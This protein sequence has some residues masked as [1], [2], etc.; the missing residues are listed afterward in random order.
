MP[1]LR[2]ALG[3][4]GFGNV[5]TYVQS[6][7]IVLDSD[8]PADAVGARV[9]ALIAAEFDLEIPVVTRTGDDLARIVAANP[10]AD[11]AEDPKRYQVT[12]LSGALTA[13]TVQRL[14]SLATD[15][16]QLVV[17][18]REVFAWH[19]EGVAR[20]KL[21][22]ALAGKLGV[23]ATARNWTTVTT[24]LQMASD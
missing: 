22:T 11:C 4:A 13:E 20:S 23:V 8:L 10:L 12:F 6:G 5:Q 15:S 9:G 24:L 16:E 18:D 7:N 3:A 14:E 21:S 17:Q 2:D 19:P 1:A